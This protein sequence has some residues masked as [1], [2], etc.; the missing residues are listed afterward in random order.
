MNKE[1]NIDGISMIFESNENR[2]EIFKQKHPKLS[3]ILELAI[4]CGMSDVEYDISKVED[5]I[6]WYNDS[7]QYDIKQNMRYYNGSDVLD[8]PFMVE[9]KNDDIDIIS[10]RD[11][12]FSVIADAPI[13]A[14]YGPPFI[15]RTS[16][17]E[18]TM[19]DD[20]QIFKWRFSISKYDRLLSNGQKYTDVLKDI[21]SDTN[22]CKELVD[23]YKASDSDLIELYTL[24]CQLT[25]SPKSDWQILKLIEQSTLFNYVYC[26]HL[27]N[28]LFDKG[29]KEYLE[30]TEILYS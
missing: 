12:I 5:T 15:F 6:S 17:A 27:I 22:I 16:N 29:K 23:S 21:L 4:V 1:S 9:L 13:E 20:F 2:I 19:D 11:Y 3:K 26:E 10:L 8:M 25:T 7:L 18:Y 14:V 24:L 28:Y 30:V